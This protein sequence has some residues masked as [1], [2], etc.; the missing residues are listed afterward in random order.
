[1]E[2]HNKNNI[3]AEFA[4]STNRAKPTSQQP[5]SKQHLLFSCLLNHGLI[6]VTDNQKHSIWRRIDQFLLKLC[7]NS[8]QHITLDSVPTEKIQS[9]ESKLTKNNDF[10]TYVFIYIGQTKGNTWNRSVFQ[11]SWIVRRVT[12]QKGLPVFVCICSA[13]EVRV[14]WWK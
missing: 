6:S 8:K 2:S 4:V 9:R 14:C 7:M 5:V 1:M 3:E 12:N 10:D 13:S 11:S